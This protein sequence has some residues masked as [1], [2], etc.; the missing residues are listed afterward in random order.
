MVAVGYE[1]E[2]TPIAC[3]VRLRNVLKVMSDPELAS[4]AR[5]LTRS[6]STGG[7]SHFQSTKLEMVFFVALL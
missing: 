1:F 5:S 3:M 6:A 7:T 4:R 2:L